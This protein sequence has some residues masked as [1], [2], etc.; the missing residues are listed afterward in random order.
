M[1]YRSSDSEYYQTKQ[2][3]QEAA[4]LIKL[5]D[6]REEALNAARRDGGPYPITGIPEGID[7]SSLCD[8]Y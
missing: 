8:G 3:P 5:F 2:L 7:I 6:T 4:G 1:G